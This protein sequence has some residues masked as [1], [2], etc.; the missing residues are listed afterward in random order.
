MKGGVLFDTN[1]AFKY[2][3]GNKHKEDENHSAYGFYIQSS[4]GTSVINVSIGYSPLLVSKRRPAIEFTMN[5]STTPP[6]DPLTAHI[7]LSAHPGTG[8]E[9]RRLYYRG[10]SR[11]LNAHGAG[12]KGMWAHSYSGSWPDELTKGLMSPARSDV[13][14]DFPRETTGLDR[15]GDMFYYADLDGMRGGHNAP[16]KISAIER[17]N[18]EEAEAVDKDSL[19][20]HLD[21]KAKSLSELWEQGVQITDGLVTADFLVLQLRS[22][23]S[24]WILDPHIKKHKA[25]FVVLAFDP[26]YTPPMWAREAK[27]YMSI[28]EFADDGSKGWKDI[29]G[30]YT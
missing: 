20:I 2:W 4:K 3:H 1:L 24:A 29:C 26:G 19:S 18:T 6:L 10:M 16:L 28:M 9:T 22:K 27:E 25:A 14:F 5:T 13:V 15:I 7:W 8:C 12:Q 23:M 21:D 30:H 11:C 17:E